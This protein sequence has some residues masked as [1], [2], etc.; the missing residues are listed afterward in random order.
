MLMASGSKRITDG[1][2]SLAVL[3][4]FD[5]DLSVASM[6]GAIWN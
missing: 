6:C 2:T 1:T 3:Y 5:T 4:T